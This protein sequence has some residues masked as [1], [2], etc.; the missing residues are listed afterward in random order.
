MASVQRV[1][2]VIE[3]VYAADGLTIA[4]QVRMVHSRA[5]TLLVPPNLQLSKPS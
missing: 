4:C 5:S 3:R 1:G 2:R